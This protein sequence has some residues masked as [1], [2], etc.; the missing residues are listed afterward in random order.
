[1]TKKK[2]FLEEKTDIM[3]DISSLCLSKVIGID[4]KL[5]VITS[6]CEYDHKGVQGVCFRTMVF[7]FE[8]NIDIVWDDDKPA[9]EYLK[10]LVHELIHTYSHVLNFEKREN[11]DECYASLIGEIMAG[12]WENKETI[13][14][15]LKHFVSLK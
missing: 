7:P 14:R 8:A 12:V 9:S 15:L 1:M 4:I 3:C 13:D 2:R 5:R 11:P 10:T 6:N